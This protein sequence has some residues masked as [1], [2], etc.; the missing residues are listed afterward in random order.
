MG[1]IINIKFFIDIMRNEYYDNED[2]KG[3]GG[4]QQ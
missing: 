4:Y 2:G 1:K 3:N